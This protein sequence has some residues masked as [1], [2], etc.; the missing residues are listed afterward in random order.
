MKPIEKLRFAT[1]RGDINRV[2]DSWDSETRSLRRQ[3]A[4]QRQQMLFQQLGFADDSSES[5][6]RAA[7]DFAA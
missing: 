4:I 2:R 6:S 3:M 5:R 1:I 7:S